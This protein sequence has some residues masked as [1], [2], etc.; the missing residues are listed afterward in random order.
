MLDMHRSSNKEH[1]SSDGS[2]L[3]YSVLLKHLTFTNCKAIYRAAVYI[4]SNC[5][6]GNV[7]IKDCTFRNNDILTTESK[8]NELKGGSALYLT[9]KNSEI[10]MCKFKSN[11]GE[12][13]SLKINDNFDL[14]PNGITKLQKV[15][16]Y[17]EGSDFK[18]PI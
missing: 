2:T 18:M 17:S 15:P 10:V 5:P 7:Y 11:K 12:G 3:T 14:T 8:N 4:Y 16:N 1:T 13:G 6:S 9:V